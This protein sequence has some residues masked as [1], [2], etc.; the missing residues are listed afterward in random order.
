MYNASNLTQLVFTIV[1]I[2]QY[3]TFGSWRQFIPATLFTSNQTTISVF[4]LFL[5]NVPQENNTWQQNYCDNNWFNLTI[6]NVAVYANHTAQC[7]IPITVS[8]SLLQVGNLVN[9]QIYDTNNV[10]VAATTFTLQPAIIA[11]I[12]AKQNS[13]QMP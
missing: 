6:N 1:N 13:V 8:P 9:Y 5:V 12:A 2:T 3:Q 11:V 4:N 10:L 7:I